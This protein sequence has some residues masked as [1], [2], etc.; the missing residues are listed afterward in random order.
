MLSQATGAARQAFQEQQ[1]ALSG[2]EAVE[3]VTEGVHWKIQTGA[4]GGTA[5]TRWFSPDHQCPGGFV[6]LAQKV[7]GQ[8]GLTGGLLS[9]VNKLLY[10]EIIGM[11]GFGSQDTPGL[12]SAR[13]LDS[14][15]PQ[16]D[17]HFGVFTTDEQAARQ[18]LAWSTAALADWATRYP[19]KQMQTPGK[20]FGQLVVM[21]C[22]SGTYVASLGSMIPEALQEMTTL[23]VALVKGK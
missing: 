16:L 18:Y 11:Y 20:V 1:E 22:P 21:I 14:F 17:P 10:H 2:P 8:A 6:F 23:G 4:L 7:A 12:D 19:L 13:L 15:D 3:H 5:V 9:G